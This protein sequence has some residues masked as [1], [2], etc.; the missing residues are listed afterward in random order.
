[1]GHEMSDMYKK[2][3]R[4]PTAWTKRSPEILR[5]FRDCGRCRRS[6]C[7]RTG[8]LTW[9]FIGAAGRNRTDDLRITNAIRTRG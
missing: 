6:L 2:S 4:L 7:N 5:T 3:T 9:P 1:M 8:G